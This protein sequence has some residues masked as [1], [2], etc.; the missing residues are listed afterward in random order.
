MNPYVRPDV[1]ETRRGDPPTQTAR[2]AGLGTRRA[3]GPDW[4]DEI[5]GI[6]GAIFPPPSAFSTAEEH[7]SPTRNAKFTTFERPQRQKDSEASLSR[8]ASKP[9]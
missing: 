7:P 1:E 5:E 9:M 4:A 6:R 2:D 3:T 8:S